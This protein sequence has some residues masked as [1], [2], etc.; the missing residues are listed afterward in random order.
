MRMVEL[1][2]EFLSYFLNNKFKV[3]DRLINILWLSK[4]TYVAAIFEFK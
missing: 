4:L 2:K 3:S 1:G